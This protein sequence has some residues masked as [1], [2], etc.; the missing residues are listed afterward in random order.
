MEKIINIYKPIG[1]TPFQLIQEFKKQNKEYRTLALSHAGKLDPLAEGVMIFLAENYIKKIKK[2]MKLDK[3]YKAKILFGFSSDSYDIQGLGKKENPN[4]D[5]EKLKQEIEKLKG[6]Y[7]QEIPPFSGRTV[8]GKPLF[9]WARS[10]RLNEIT[11]PKEKVIIKE[12]KLNS[13]NNISS[14]ELLK[15]I[16]N[17]IILLKGDFRQEEISNQWKKIL[18]ENNQYIVIELTIDCTS[19]TYIRGIAN[20]LGKK[21]NS[22]AILLNLI[23]TKIGDFSIE[24]SIRI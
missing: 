23:R 3:Q 19:G 16:I 15:E 1:L 2:F 17:K 24:K 20:D 22:G 5:K 18:K 14:S 7:I 4:I 6:E 11:I 10:N 12:I 13:I 9:Q 21:L 8:N